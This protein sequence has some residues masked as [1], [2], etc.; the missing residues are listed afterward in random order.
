VGD[1]ALA[2]S[3]TTRSLQEAFRHRFDMTPMQFLRRLRLRLARE[4]LLNGH[5]LGLTVHDVALRWGFSHSGRFAQQ[6]LAEFGEHPSQ[7]LRR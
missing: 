1:I 7:T 3:T 4:Q 5:D 2:A 6:Y